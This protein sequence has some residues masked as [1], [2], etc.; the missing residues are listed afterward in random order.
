MTHTEDS[1]RGLAFAI[2][3]YL[4]WGGLP[5]YL[6]AI[7]HVPALEV[8]SHRIIWSVPVAS[9]ILII[10]GRTRDIQTALKSPKLLA[11]ETLTAALISINWLTYVYAISTQRTLDAALGYYINPLFSV[12]LGFILLRERMR[13]LQWVAVCF[14]I[15]A[16][17][18]LAYE[19]GSL[20]WISLTLTLSWGFYALFKR[21]LPIGPNQGFLL[22]VLVLSPIAI[23][24]LMY[25]WINGTHSFANVSWS[26]TM[27]LMG[28]GVVTAVP[29]IVYANGAKLLRL[30][31]IGMLQYIAPTFIFLTAVFIFDEPF[32]WEKKIAF[33]MIWVALAIYSASLIKTRR[34]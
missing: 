5:L 30:S 27:L 32:G 9:I 18:V 29:L 33:P 22:E 6:K 12:F 17:V 31:T 10:L 24:Y 1:P 26:T 8:V 13:P 4:M 19:L 11:M 25:L 20:P 14:A 28:S 2:A 23:G 21:S 16:V 3:A 34:P 7:S 15:G